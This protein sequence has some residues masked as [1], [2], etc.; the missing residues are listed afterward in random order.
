MN[1]F[2]IVFLL[3]MTFPVIL[4]VSRVIAR[5]PRRARRMRR[6][7]FSYKT[8]VVRYVRTSSLIWLKRCYFTLKRMFDYAIRMFDYVAEYLLSP[9]SY[10]TRW[11]QMRTGK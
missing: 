8:R 5:M 6:Y 9:F 7:V 3:S 1:L 11:I 2:M 10:I 4:F